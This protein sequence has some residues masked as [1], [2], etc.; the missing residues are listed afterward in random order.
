MKTKILINKLLFHSVASCTCCTKTN[1]IEYHDV[2]CMYRTLMEAADGLKQQTTWHPATQ[3]P[4]LNT[5]KPVLTRRNSPFKYGL[6]YK[7]KDEKDQ[8]FWRFDSEVTEWAY[9]ED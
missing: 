5:E 6:V 7:L 8:P 1:V 4:A 2:N 9:I 3:L